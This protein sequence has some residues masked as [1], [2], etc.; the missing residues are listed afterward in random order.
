M[1]TL[2]LVMGGVIFLDLYSDN[3]RGQVMESLKSLKTIG[4]FVLPF[5]PGL[6]LSMMAAKTQTKY[7]ELVQKM[8][9]TETT[10]SKTVAKTVA[11]PASPAPAKP[12]AKK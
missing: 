2:F 1:S 7:M 8:T 9:A 11:K 3:I 4:I 10:D 12:K 6:V 5:L